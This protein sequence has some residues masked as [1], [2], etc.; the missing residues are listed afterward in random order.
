MC[1]SNLD[2]KE[3]KVIE[4]E[5]FRVVDATSPTYPIHDDLI[6]VGL[7][8]GG[9]WLTT[10]RALELSNAIALVANANIARRQLITKDKP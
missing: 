1:E 8:N 6:W 4:V 2:V 9:R 5:G 3:H 7:E 10:E